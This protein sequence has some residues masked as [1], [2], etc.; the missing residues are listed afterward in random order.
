MLHFEFPGRTFA[1]LVLHVVA[2]EIEPVAAELE[3]ED[4]I[5]FRNGYR[6][7][8]IDQHLRMKFYEP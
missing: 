4:G 7:K 5:S 3:A 8:N 6:N 2:V 1:C